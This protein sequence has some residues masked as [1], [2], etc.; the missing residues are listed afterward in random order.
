MVACGQAVATWRH[1]PS[2]SPRRNSGA[3]RSCS[4]SKVGRHGDVHVSPRRAFRARGRSTRRSSGRCTSWGNGVSL[5]GCVVRLQSCRTCSAASFGLSLN[6][7]TAHSL[8]V[9]TRA[10]GANARSSGLVQVV[11]RGLD[12]LAAGDVDARAVLEAL[13]RW[14]WRRAAGL[15]GLIDEDVEVPVEVDAGRFAGVV[16]VADHGRDRISASMMPGLPWTWMKM[17]VL[18]IAYS[19]SGGPGLAP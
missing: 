7:R 2:I 6:S 17:I 3:A 18:L 15:L 1:L 16:Q 14:P 12:P 10:P 9:R 8:T 19:P 5:G 13:D 11:H 4:S